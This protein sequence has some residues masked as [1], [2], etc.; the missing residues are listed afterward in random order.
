FLDFWGNTDGYATP[1]VLPDVSYNPSQLFEL[2]AVRMTLNNGA[3]TDTD[4]LGNFRI[5]LPSGFWTLRADFG[6][7]SKFA[8]VLDDSGPE[9]QATNTVQSKKGLFGWVSAFLYNL[10]KRQFRLNTLRT[11]EDTAE[12]NA[13]RHIVRFRNWVRS[14]NPSDSKMDFRVSAVVNVAAT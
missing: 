11:E 13:Q 14:I 5:S 6:P 9:V 12:V 2:E 10:N 7:S 8:Y 1:G 4:A 3:Y